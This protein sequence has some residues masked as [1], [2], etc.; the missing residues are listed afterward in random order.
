LSEDQTGCGLYLVVEVGTSALERLAA[1]LGAASVACVLIEPAKAEALT[2]AAARPLIEMVQKQG[3]AALIAADTRLA[4]SVKADGVHLPWS[5]HLAEAYEEARELLGDRSVVGVH[6]G[7]SRH[8][9]MLLAE[10]GADYIGFGLPV[11]VKDRNA[12]RARRLELVSW[13][14]EIFTVPCVA[15]DVET[16]ED[17]DALAAAGAD[18]VSCKLSAGST[19]A[20]A[21]DRVAAIDRAIRRAARAA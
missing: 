15:F 20:D 3:A 16:S 7:K 10:R 21:A 19:P 9:A 12:G 13:W 17:A 8:D 5:K 2:A 14:A 18:F 6:A 4:R 1:A 11:E